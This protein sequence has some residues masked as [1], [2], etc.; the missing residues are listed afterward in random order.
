MT[1]PHQR[2]RHLAVVRGGAPEQVAARW[3]LQ[4][5]N[6]TMVVTGVERGVG[7]TFVAANLAVALSELGSKVLLANTVSND[8]AARRMVGI[9]DT[10]VPRSSIEGYMD[11]HAAG[12]R[13]LLATHPP[14]GGGRDEVGESRRLQN[15]GH[16][17]PLAD[18]LV[19]E[20]PGDRTAMLKQCARSAQRVIIVA[21]GST[22][23]SA[24]T[25]ALLKSLAEFRSSLQ[26]LLLFNKVLAAAP[27]RRHMQALSESASRFL[28]LRIAFLGTVP[29]DPTAARS[30]A[31]RTPLVRSGPES[32]AGAAL[33]AMARRLHADTLVVPPALEVEP[34]AGAGE[35]SAA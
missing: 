15:L 23:S 6:P 4:T 29:M 22:S 5:D 17:D 12:E 34:T 16:F 14:S 13:L 11:I 20:V 31:D 26:V 33:W 2:S 32:P 7:K 8:D 18:L 21:S 28:K 10:S 19:V 9:A 24:S 25:Y 3:S 35:A 30:V 27:L 1:A